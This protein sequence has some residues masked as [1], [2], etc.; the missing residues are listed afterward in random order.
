MA[1]PV[2]PDT[3]VA[4]ETMNAP[5]LTPSIVMPV[6][7]LP[8]DEMLSNPMP[9]APM[10]T[11]SRSSAWPPVDMMLSSPAVA[12]TETVPPPVALKPVPVVVSMF[13]PPVNAISAPVLST[14]STPVA[15]E[16]LAVTRP[17]NVMVPPVLLVTETATA[18]LFWVIVPL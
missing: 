1:L 14:R 5:P 3:V 10:L 4:P 15:V 9:P 6:V 16:V 18:A 7:A 17:A 12:E 13:S 8:V 2:E 11:P